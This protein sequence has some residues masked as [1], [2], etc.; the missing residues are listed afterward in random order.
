MLSVSDIFE[1]VNKRTLYRL[2]KK[3]NSIFWGFAGSADELIR[4]L[5]NGETTILMVN[6]VLQKILNIVT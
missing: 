3:Y 6:K 5:A 2:T 4:H 1:S